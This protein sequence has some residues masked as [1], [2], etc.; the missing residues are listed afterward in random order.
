MKGPVAIG[1]DR[2]CRTDLERHSRL[3]SEQGLKA[4]AASSQHLKTASKVPSPPDC[5][6]IC[7]EVVGGN[8]LL[9]IV[10]AL[11]VDG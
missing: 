7:L 1:E 8:N 10:R 5:Q 9:N 4:G 3:E 6:Q 2:H 11:Q